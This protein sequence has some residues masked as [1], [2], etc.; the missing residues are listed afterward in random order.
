MPLGP[1]PIPQAQHLRRESSRSAH[2]DMSNPNM[3]NINRGFPPNGGR[4]R[5]FNNPSYGPQMAHSSPG[6]AFRQLPNQQRGA[7]NMPPQFQN[8]GPIGQPNSPFR[9]NRSPV[10]TPAAVHSQVHLA[11]NPQMQ[12]PPYGHPQHFQSQTVRSLS[13]FPQQQARERGTLGC[14]KYTI[15]EDMTK[16]EQLR[17]KARLSAIADRPR[18]LGSKRSSV[19]GFAH[20]QTGI[21]AHRNHA[22]LLLKD[23]S[24]FF[25]LSR[26]DLQKKALSDNRDSYVT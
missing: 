9:Q 21:K 24:G 7:Q 12:Y 5:G 15:S 10:L 11:N 16:G 2:S 20:G 14:I 13:P 22:T 8:H 19:L 26:D 18:I 3:S 23:R 1:N 17:K 6:P 25:M 4:S